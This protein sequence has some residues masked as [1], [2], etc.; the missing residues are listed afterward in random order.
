[1]NHIHN[2]FNIVYRKMGQWPQRIA[3]RIARNAH[4]GPYGSCEVWQSLR[5]GMQEWMKVMCADTC[6]VLKDLL[7]DFLDDAHERH[8][9]SE[10]NIG[11]LVWKRNVEGS[12]L[13]F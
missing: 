7:P 11:Q 4:L 8:R 13:L 12:R 6:F 1:M 5:Q 2:D 3:M 10:P 9:I